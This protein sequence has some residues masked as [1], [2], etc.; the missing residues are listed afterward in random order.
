MTAPTL[1]S[2]IA[3]MQAEAAELD[4]WQ[5]EAAARQRMVEAHISAFSKY[6]AVQSTYTTLSMLYAGLNPRLFR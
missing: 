5:R 1:T 6:L 2:R 3:A 4:R